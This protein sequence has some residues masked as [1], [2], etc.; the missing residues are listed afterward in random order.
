MRNFFLI[1]TDHL[2]DSLWFKDNDDFKVGMNMV[3]VQ[4]SLSD[5]F[6]LAFIL[7]SNHVH[8]I[9]Y[10]TKEEAKEFIKR[11]KARYSQYYCR[12]WGV[13]EFLR[14]NY[15]DVKLVP[16]T[17]DT[18]ER[19]IAYVLMNCV[20]AKICSYPT[21][22]PWGC[23]RCFFNA[24]SIRNCRRVKDFSKRALAKLL[25][26]D[27][28]GLPGEWIISDSG[29]VLPE[30]YIQVDQV[31]RL[32]RTPNRLD[33]FL[34]TSSKAK[35][36]LEMSEEAMPSFKDQI[37]LSAV[38]DLCQSLFQKYGFNDLNES[39]RTEVLRQLKYRFSASP[40]QLSRVCGLTYAETAR[41]LDK[42]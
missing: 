35:K 33:Y 29:Y 25:H 3:A 1:S 31:E 37:I 23:G 27:V 12:K 34:R 22:Y 7:M 13:K 5:I 38:P 40:N 32:F 17:P 14:L 39:E 4:A 8:F 2:E 9:V 11:Y 6:I 10:G 30:S 41:L 20:A 42:Y 18:L 21:Q 26:S 16:D 15:A 19:A 24:D 36:V 28:N